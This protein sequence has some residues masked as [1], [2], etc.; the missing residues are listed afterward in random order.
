MAKNMVQYLHVLD[1]EIPIDIKKIFQTTN[2]FVV[3]GEIS[4]FDLRTSPRSSERKL[5]SME[6][7]DESHIQWE[8][9]RIQYMEVRKRTIFLAI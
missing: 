5:G 3:F 2:Q 7:P 9:F 6:I 8:I 1:P 4:W